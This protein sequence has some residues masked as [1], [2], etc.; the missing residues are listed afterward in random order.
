MVN[1]LN[2]KKLPVVAV[3]NVV[4]FPNVIAPLFIGRESSSNAINEAVFRGGQVIVLTQVNSMTDEINPSNL[5]KIGTLCNIAHISKVPN[6]I[7]QKV[8]LDPTERVKII[9]YE[10]D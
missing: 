1:K 9:E 10:H 2:F 4:I 7:E 3:R 6:T 8:I 5:Y